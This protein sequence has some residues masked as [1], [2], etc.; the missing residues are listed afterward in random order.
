MKASARQCCP[1]TSPSI[2]AAHR[3]QSRPQGSSAADPVDDPCCS[4]A[5]PASER[6]RRR[7]AKLVGVEPQASFADVIN[8]IVNGHPNSRIDGLLP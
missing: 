5:G 6:W 4:R 7:E 8:R 2:P 3:R 1:A